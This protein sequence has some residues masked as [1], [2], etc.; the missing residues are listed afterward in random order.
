MASELAY[1]KMG[2]GSVVVGL[3]V[4]GLGV[5]VVYYGADGEAFVVPHW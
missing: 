3:Y 5:V 1:R 2:D 4:V